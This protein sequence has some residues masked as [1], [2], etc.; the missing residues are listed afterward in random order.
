MADIS[1]S[2]AAGAALDLEN[3]NALLR[4]SLADLQ[5]R[6]ADLERRVESDPLTGLPDR[7]RFLAE[8]ERAVGQAQRHGTP[9]AVLFIDVN[10]LGRINHARGFL[11]G[12]AALVHVAAQ[13][14]AL[15]RA[16]DTVARIGGDSFGL[17][18]DH[19]DPNSAIETSERLARCIAA[20]PADLGGS[21]ASVT[22]SIGVTS[23]LPGDS[24]EEVM[25]RGARNVGLAKEEG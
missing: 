1:N 15:I 24:V 19:L 18:L 13:L 5:S 20:A 9:S 6:Y 7:R 3:E 25:R 17:I 16:T 10:G 8:V 2:P 12:D 22:V 21:Q 4:A 23:I 14:S 11:A